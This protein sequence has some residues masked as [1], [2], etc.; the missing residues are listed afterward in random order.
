MNDMPLMELK[1]YWQM[2]VYKKYVFIA[3]SLLCLSII[4]WGSFL[5]PEIYEA[6]S[7]VFI[8]RSIL[9]N[10]VKNIAIT[11]TMMDER[12]R[13]ISYTMKSRNLLLKVIDEL[14]FDIDM[15]NPAAVEKLVLDFQ[16]N[17]KIKMVS[18]AK[19]GTDLFTVS[20]RNKDP[21]LT[22][23]YVNTLVR[24]A[25]EENISAKRE[26]AYEANRFL[27]E[28]RAF[29][30]KKL[31]AAVEKI[32][33]F[34]K[35]KGIFMAID[36]RIIVGEIKVAQDSLE[37]LNIKMS[38]LNA[39]KAS[40]EKQLKEENIYTV[41]RLGSST[42]ASLS[43]KI[44]Y[45]HQKLNELLVK[46]T[47]NYPEVI[48]IKAAIEILQKQLD[49]G[50][51]QE[52]AFEKDGDATEMTTLNPL[53]QQ[54]KE[55]LSKIDLELAALT[56]KEKHLKRIIESKKAY[57]RNIPEEKKDLAELERDRDTYKRIDA[58]LVLK[59]G[60][61]EVS[62][63]MEVQDKAE[64]FRI[65]DPAILPTKPVSPNRVLIIL[66]GIV[67]GLA[68]GFGAVFFLDN[69]D[70]S[71]KTPEGIKASFNLPVLAVIPRIVTEQD[72]IK[73][74]RMD[75]TVYGLS[76]AY[77]AVIGGLFVKEVIDRLTL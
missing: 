17:T 60:A 35:D 46:Y 74:K 52:V 64:T 67:A 77:L 16:E 48:K 27:T 73:M 37:E 25:V 22:M 53:Y 28:Q 62:K 34:R 76:I 68:G 47:E 41:S 3:V 71:I 39:K 11:T 72:K 31:N 61:T 14:D 21:K 8:E 45:L 33:N 1:K 10:L 6:K 42:G 59:I 51:D 66:F 70:N 24:M 26:E 44:L 75:R 43:K 38:E 57:L 49:S 19:K 32:S 69:M 55:E 63:Y 36:E 2:I 23:D 56:A 15:N 30:K 20:Y 58:E 54:L 40:T 7:T 50:G 65:V 4:V 12:L 18:K 13:V 29:F 9:K 5:K